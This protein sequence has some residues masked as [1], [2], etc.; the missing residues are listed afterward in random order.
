MPCV[1]R[2][3]WSHFGLLLVTKKSWLEW[4]EC[5]PNAKRK[6]ENQW[7]CKRPS[8]EGWAG[9]DVIQSG[10]V[11][12]GGQTPQILVRPPNINDKII[13]STRT[14]SPIHLFLDEPLQ[15]RYTA[16]KT[17]SQD[18]LDNFDGPLCCGSWPSLKFLTWLWSQFSLSAFRSAVKVRRQKLDVDKSFLRS[19]IRRAQVA[20][21][22]R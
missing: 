7:V 16:W 11:V 14:R 6:A 2:E 22:L 8:T 3:V 13:R 18:R 10:A 9:L 21:A 12:T 4:I 17:F 1:Q 5:Y 20:C 15:Y 19:Q